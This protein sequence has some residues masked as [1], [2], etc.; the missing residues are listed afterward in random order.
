M[1]SVYLDP[2]FTDE[3]RRQQLY[4]GQLIVLSPRESTL[5]FCDFAKTLI[6]EAFD[7]LTRWN[8]RRRSFI[9]PWRSMQ[10]YCKN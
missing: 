7:P 5:A 2:P 4:G 8:L 6:Q 9:C 1:N 3:S 10:K